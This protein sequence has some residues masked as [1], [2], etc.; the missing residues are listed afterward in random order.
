MYQPPSGPASA[1][2][3]VS[4]QPGA[5]VG[6]VP[7]GNPYSQGLYPQGGYDDYQPHPHHSQH[8]QQHSLGLNQAGVGTGDYGKQLYGSGNLG[9]QGFMGPGGQGAGTGGPNSNAGGPRGAGSPETPYKYA[10]KDVG[11]V[12][13]GRGAGQQGQG[14][15]QPQGQSHGGQV[16]QGQGFYGGA[17]FGAGAG[18]GGAGGVAGPQ[19]SAHHP[20]NGPQGHPGYPQN[21]NDGNF[22]QYRGQQQ[23]YWQ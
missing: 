23:G 21:G 5:G 1:P 17:R 12:S 13:A 4:K 20:Q 22:Y 7:Q 8:S 6:A 15:G 11:S 19:Q 14:Q 18:I 2:S 10:A 9:I 16:P 3:P